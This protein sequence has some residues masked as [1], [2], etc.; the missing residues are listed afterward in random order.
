MYDKV[1]QSLEERGGMAMSLYE[2]G[3]AA[4]KPWDPFNGFRRFMCNAFLFKKIQAKFGGRFRLFAAGAAPLSA[5]LQ[6]FLQVVFNCP[7]VQGYGLT[8]NAC[9]AA[10]MPLG[11]TKCGNVGGPIP[12]LEIKLQDTEAYK[13]T[14]VYPKT[15]A[16]FEAQVSFKG[17]FDPSLAGRTVPRGEVCL[18]GSNVF[19]GYYKNDKDTAETLDDEG[20]LHTGDVGVWNADGSQGPLRSEPRRPDS[21]ARGGVSAGVQRVAGYYKNDKDTAE[22]LDDEGWLHT[23]DV[24][25]WNADG[26]LSIVD[27]KKNIFKL[28]QGEYVSPEAVEIAIGTSKWA[29]QV[30]V[31][32]NSFE[33]YPV[34]ICTPDVEVMKQ[35]AQQNGKAGTMADW[36]KDPEVKK[37]IFADIIA[38]GKAAK[39]R[40]FELPK[41]IAFETTINEFGQ[42]FTIDQDLLT[43]TLKLRRPQLL[44]KYQK[45]IDEMYAEIR[46]EEASAKKTEGAKV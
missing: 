10:A 11:Y 31:Y 38:S 41:K 25:V 16:E 3:M 28:A 17:H 35:W 20:W 4:D 46:E 37:M 36:V 15:K 40:S 2:W 24:G 23:G 33:N 42:G 30:W 27:R 12:C 45:V 14:D 22:T 32:G 8:E 6:R 26:S 44:K 39:L 1:V 34:V 43:P 19:A 9:V 29:L 7:V 5:E 13:C 18:R 21:A